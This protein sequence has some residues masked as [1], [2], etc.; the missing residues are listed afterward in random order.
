MDVF[1]ELHS[2]LAEASLLD[3]Y[4]KLKGVI[5]SGGPASVYAEGAP[6][7]SE[8]MW[9]EI[10]RRNLPVLGI[11]YGLQ[12]TVFRM[13]GAVSPSA[14]REFGHAKLHPVEG[15]ASDLFAGLVEEGDEGGFQVRS[16][17]RGVALV[18]RR[19]HGC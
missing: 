13:G 8:S 17:Q 9:A 7:V 14:H 19:A 5:L 6:H 11:C 10:E 2:C 3:Q 4:P 12:E 18:A 16:R 15:H 1:C